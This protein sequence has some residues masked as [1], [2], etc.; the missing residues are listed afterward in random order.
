MSGAQWAKLAAAARDRYAVH[1][2]DLI[3]CGR[4][5][6]M[7]NATLAD[8]VDAVVA[9]LAALPGPALVVGHS[10]GGLVAVEAALVA[11][12]RIRALALY[13]PVI[14]ALA[15]EAGSALAQQQV[16]RIDAIMAAAIDDG[17]RAWVEQFID[18][19]N[20]DGFFARLPASAQAQNVATALV[21]RRQVEGVRQQTVSLAR[22]ATLTTPTLLLTG[23]T[24]PAA[25]R[26]AA[27]LAVS[28][29]A[30]AR[31]DVV[32]GAG[33]LGPLTHGAE[34]NAR[35]LAFFDVVVGG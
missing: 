6:D 30:R 9:L 8:D 2:P 29:M 24:S 13:E 1:V 26:E 27:A 31:V 17:G 23:E 10:Y 22:L 33:H 12:E 34:V 20:G 19:W 32:V 14:V 25:A 3:G 18:W 35:L 5:P 21:S 4:T 16:G 15:K 28:V 7:A 11:P